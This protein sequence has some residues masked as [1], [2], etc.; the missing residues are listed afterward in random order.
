MS[1]LDMYRS[2]VVSTRDEMARLQKQK[3]EE[4]SKIAEANRRANEADA[5]A[6]RASNASIADGR[7]RE[8][9]RHHREVADRQRTLADLE[10]KLATK[11]EDL[12]RTEN[13][14]AR[15]ERR[16]ADSQERERKRREQE[17]ERQER[18]RKR[19][20]QDEERE[21]K[22][23]EQKQ[24]RARK[25]RE[26]DHERRMRE[27]TNKLGS[28]DRIHRETLDALKEIQRLPEE[29]TV[30]LLA[31]N[32]MDTERL[33]LDGEVRAIH[34]MIRRSEHRDAV[35]LQ[36]RWAV[37]AGDLIQAINEC[38][39]TIVHFSG[40]GTNR[41]EIVLED[42]QGNAK[43]VGMDAIT[44]M[45]AACS[46]SIRLVFFNMCYSASQA[47]SVVQHVEVAIGMRDT[48]GD[49]TARLFA[50][51][52]YSSIG[53]GKSVQVAFEQA[54]ARIMLEGI[55]EEDVPELFV[56]DGIDPGQVMIVRPPNP[57]GEPP[58]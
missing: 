6:G 24:E 23:G 11:A 18:E 27:I 40:H 28:H 57:A 13:D 38:T 39:P 8:A 42:D 5:A 30:L 51:Q 17:Q 31:A 4:A 1:L 3:A 32:P 10:R 16:E 19:R 45:M 34:D 36:S 56:R 12:H 44:Q 55:A 41:E 2:K 29:I 7:R 22:R 35:K 25:R 46:G 52:F 43:P 48:V 33:R 21:R 15:E 54:K 9:E 50:S 49:D 37:Q 26:Q 53:F 58:I 14:L 20:E 47:R